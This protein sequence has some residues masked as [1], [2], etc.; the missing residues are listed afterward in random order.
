MCVSRCVPHLLVGTLGREAKAS[1]YAMG[2]FRSDVRKSFFMGG[3]ARHGNGLPR[4][5]VGL[6]SLEVVKKYG[7]WCIGTWFSSGLSM[8][9]GWLDLM[10]LE[11]FSNP[12]HSN[13]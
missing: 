1:S 7:M 10:F 6:P 12:T 3:V 8:L 5:V 2:R 4:E 11:V 9:G 13:D